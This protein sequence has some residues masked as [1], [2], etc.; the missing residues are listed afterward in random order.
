MGKELHF[1]FSKKPLIGIHEGFRDGVLPIAG[2]MV[3]TGILVAIFA[4]FIH[5]GSGMNP[6]VP[7]HLDDGEAV[8]PSPTRLVFMC[9][10]F[11]S[12]FLFGWLA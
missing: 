7:P 6:V 1:S 5:F 2:I 9:L 4:V 3:L 10:A 12:A 8:D 11:V